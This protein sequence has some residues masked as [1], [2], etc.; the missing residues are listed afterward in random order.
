MQ[1]S[2]ITGDI[3]DEAQRA[4]ER[5]KVAQ[6]FTL[7]L[8][9]IPVGKMFKPLVGEQVTDYI[10]APIAKY[11]IGDVDKSIEGGFTGNGVASAT[12]A[13]NDAYGAAVVQTRVQ[14]LYS[15]VTT[16]VIDDSGTH[17]TLPSG[18]LANDWPSDE[19]GNP[20]T[21]GELTKA[22]IA[23]IMQSVDND[24]YAGE[25]NQRIQYTADNEIHKVTGR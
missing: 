20:K 23:S 2:M 13:G 5:R 14:A 16:D 9:V 3:D 25:V 11:I 8:D 22:D 21:P 10:A 7:P 12:S 18:N 1:D 4:E 19:Y 24:G 15:L 17:H 6:L